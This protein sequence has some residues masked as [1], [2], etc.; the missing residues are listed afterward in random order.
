MQ[1]SLGVEELRLE[2]F[3]QERLALGLLSHLRPLS[4]PDE[5]TWERQ[6]P[7]PGRN[8]TSTFVPTLRQLS[9]V[10]PRLARLQNDDWSGGDFG[11][12]VTGVL[13]ARPNLRI[14]MERNRFDGSDAMLKD[15]Q[16]RFKVLPDPSPASG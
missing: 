1:S 16:A 11:E 2:S 9:F 8:Q 10:G 7:E 6:S 14:E 13:D 3:A 4:S 15:V 5:T 12:L